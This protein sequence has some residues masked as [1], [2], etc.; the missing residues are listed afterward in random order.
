[1]PSPYLSQAPGGSG[2]IAA[3][4]AQKHKLRAGWGLRTPGSTGDRHHRVWKESGAP[5][6]TMGCPQTDGIA[7]IT[8]LGTGV[9]PSAPSVSAPLL[10]APS[11]PRACTQK[12]GC[13]GLGEGCPELLAQVWVGGPGQPRVEFPKDEPGAGRCHVATVL[14]RVRLPSGDLWGA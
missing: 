12:W 6:V 4:D 2:V 1:M 14:L 13:L 7:A 10:S 3:L 8:I 9:I 11:A 5:E